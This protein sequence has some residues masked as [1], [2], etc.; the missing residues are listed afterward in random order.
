MVC[1]LVDLFVEPRYRHRPLLPLFAAEW[2]VVIR[3]Q[4]SASA[5][6]QILAVA[7]LESRVCTHA[8]PPPAHRPAISRHAT[9]PRAAPRHATPRDTTHALARNRYF[10]DGE[11]KPK[12][13]LNLEGATVVQNHKAHTAKVDIRRLALYALLF[14]SSTVAPS[15]RS[16]GG[17]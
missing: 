16:C 3:H 11:I 1:M 15:S 8:R 2:G 4:S 9:P 14:C 7:C 13:V 17:A 6:S 12:G 5:G 10:K